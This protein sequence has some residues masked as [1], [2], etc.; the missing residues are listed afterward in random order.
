MTMLGNVVF[1]VLEPEQFR[2]QNGNGWI[3]LNGNTI[4]GSDLDLQYGI[5]K[6]PN[7]NGLFI[8]VI[9]LQK[10]ENRID[11]DREFGA[12]A[13]DIQDDSVKIPDLRTEHDGSHRHSMGYGVRSDTSFAHREEETGGLQQAKGG[14]NDAWKYHTSYHESEHF[15]IIKSQGYETRP[16]NIV[17]YAYIKVN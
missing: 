2:E 16:K 3:L 9:D 14:G 10:D 1:S 15:H 6:V 4:L 7:A 11:K 13:G 17:L 12:A 8:R 5:S